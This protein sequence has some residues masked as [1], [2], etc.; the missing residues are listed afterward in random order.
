MRMRPRISINITNK[1]EILI[2]IKDLAR[3]RHRYDIIDR[4]F[5]IWN[6]KQNSDQSNCRVHTHT[7]KSCVWIRLISSGWL[8]T[9]PWPAQ[10]HYFQQHVWTARAR[11]RLRSH[12]CGAIRACE[13]SPRDTRSAQLC[14]FSCYQGTK[15]VIEL[16]FLVDLIFVRIFIIQMR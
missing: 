3:R 16:V 15:T 9:T 2:L 7:F 5:E 10:T 13:C 8:P 1:I 12:V 14:R 6:T 11:A 4:E